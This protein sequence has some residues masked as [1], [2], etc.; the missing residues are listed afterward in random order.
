[1]EYI[2]IAGAVLGVV[3]QC[4]TVITIIYGLSKF[5][6]RPNASQN[7]RIDALESDMKQVKERLDNGDKH[8]G[9][10]DEGSKITQKALLA[11]IDHAIDNN[12]VD[13]LMEVKDDLQSYLIDK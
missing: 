7:Q 12:H 9:T 10:V 6:G 2:R 5:L 4:A 3:I 11:L 8:F 1:M 13:K